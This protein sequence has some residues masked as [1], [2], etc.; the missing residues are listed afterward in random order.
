MTT[1]G[2]PVNSTVHLASSVSAYQISGRNFQLVG[3]NV[4]TRTLDLFC[5]TIRVYEN[6]IN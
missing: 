6:V 4:T 3:D 1:P 5:V 2:K